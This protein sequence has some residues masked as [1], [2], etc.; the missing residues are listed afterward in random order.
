MG[1]HIRMSY[2]FYFAQDV[3]LSSLN[4]PV[5]TVTSIFGMLRAMIAEIY[6]LIHTLPT[7]YSVVRPIPGAFRGNLA[8]S[9]CL[10]Q[11][12]KMRSCPPHRF[13]RRS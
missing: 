4:N 11:A 1:Y 6:A 10:L 5:Y 2:D 9:V 12:R 13:A 3:F 8:V 7:L